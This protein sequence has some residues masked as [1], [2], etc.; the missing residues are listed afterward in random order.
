MAAFW[1]NFEYSI[2]QAMN[3][4]SNIIIN[5]DLNV[6]LLREN[7]NKLLEIISEFNI[8]NVIKEPTRNGALLDP[9]IVS[10][11]DIVIDSEVISVNRDISDHDATLINI[12]IPCLPKRSYMRK[13]WLYK[14][15]DF[16]KI[17]N[18]ILEF[19]W[20]Q[21]L[22]K[23]TDIEDMSNRFTHKYLEMVGRGIPSKLVRIRLNDKPWFNSEIRK[24]IRTR[25]RLHKLARRNQSNQSLQKYKSQ[26]NKVNNMIKYAR[27]QLFQSA[28]ELVNS[29]Q[30]KNSKSYWTFVKRMMKGR[31]HNYTIPPL[32]NESTGELVYEDKTKADLLNQYFCSITS[33]NDSNREPPNV[34]PRT[35]A[36]LSN[37][38]VNIQDV[39]DILQTLQIGKA[40]GDDGIS[41]QMLKATSETICLPLSILFRY[42]L[43]TCKFPSDWKLARVMPSFKKDDKSSPSNYRSISL[44][45]CVGKVMERVVY[46]YIY[47]YI[48]EHSLLYSYQ[49]GFLPGHSTVYQ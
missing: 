48:I 22:H 24:E 26:R 11:L 20:E 29:L 30:S 33:I 5:G 1:E 43:R 38:D 12:K 3:Y 19:Q 49:S 32:Y 4:T 21:F 44:L 35:H 27:E 36:I 10:N 45:S 18:E 15:A 40:C 42:S 16:N 34:V 41:H 6:D 7:N 23:S 13:V 31:G 37:I 8:T 17:N 47:N 14:K 25:N 28:N 9:I 39:K 46:K 2:E